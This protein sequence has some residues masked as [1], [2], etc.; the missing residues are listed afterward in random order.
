MSRTGVSK[1]FTNSIGRWEINEDGT[2]RL[3]SEVKQP[4]RVKNSRKWKKNASKEERV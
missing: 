1:T 4:I 3:I 2:I